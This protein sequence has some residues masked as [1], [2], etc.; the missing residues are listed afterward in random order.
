V[1]GSGIVFSAEAGPLLTEWPLYPVAWLFL[2][3]FAIASFWGLALPPFLAVM[4]YG[5]VLKEWNRWIGA[6]LI[7]IAFSGT[8]LIGFDYNPFTTRE[9]I[10]PLALTLG[11]ALL[12]LLAGSLWSWWFRRFR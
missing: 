6:S 7:A 11:T 9:P 8:V 10:L 2:L 1:G 12:I 3:P 5:L 4:F